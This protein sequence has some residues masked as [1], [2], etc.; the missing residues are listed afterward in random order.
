MAVD[1]WPHEKLGETIKWLQETYGPSTHQS[2]YIDYQPLCIDLV[3]DKEVYF[4]WRA[5]YD[6]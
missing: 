3:M 4:F 5:A 1:D 2:W 6:Y